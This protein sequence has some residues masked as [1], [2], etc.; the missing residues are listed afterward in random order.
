M[1]FRR[2]F[3]RRGIWLPVWD[4]FGSIDNQIS[5]ISLTQAEPILFGDDP[6]NRSTV[7]GTTGDWAAATHSGVIIKRIVGQL[8]VAPLSDSGTDDIITRVGAG[9]F[10][11]RVGEGGALNNL[12]AWNVFNE[13]SKQKR[14]LWQ[15]SWF[16]ANT[17]AQAAV[18]G[19]PVYP[20]SNA[21]YGDIRSGPHIDWKGSAKISYEERLFLVLTTVV[22]WNMAEPS[23]NGA[24]EYAAQLRAYGIPANV[25]N[26]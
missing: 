6:V 21:E 8:H 16:L 19:T 5:G 24:T 25:G 3:R 26:R 20:G 10:V 15:R 13:S 2:R 11:D 14:W 9:L 17:D 1:A 7:S 12:T 23:I 22:W 4:I 18:S